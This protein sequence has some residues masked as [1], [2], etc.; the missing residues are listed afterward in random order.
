MDLELALYVGGLAGR[1]VLGSNNEAEG[2]N[3]SSRCAPSPYSSSVQPKVVVRATTAMRVRNVSVT[4]LVMVLV[5]IS[6]LMPPFA[7][8]SALNAKSPD[9][10]Y[11]AA[12]STWLLRLQNV[13]ANKNSQFMSW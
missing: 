13:Y 6:A 8:R 2:S 4:R 9:Y 1:L 12:L 3:L 5:L 7:Y 10:L 11:Q